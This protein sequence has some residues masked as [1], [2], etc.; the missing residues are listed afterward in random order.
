[1]VVEMVGLR[2]TM[3]MTKVQKAVVGALVGGVLGVL[4]K[5]VRDYGLGDSGSFYVPQ[6]W[7]GWI[8]YYTGLAIP[9]AVVG[10]AV[11]FFWKRRLKD[12]A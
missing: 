1:M 9:A 5:V 4:W 2:E 3:A 11:G 7:A 8:A 12:S 10:A 6:T